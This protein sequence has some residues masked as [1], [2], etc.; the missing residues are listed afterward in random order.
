ME[1]IAFTIFA[2]LMQS[3]RTAGQKQM[4]QS[5]SAVVTT[6]ARYGFGFP[7]ALG[8]LVFM[9]N[10]YQQTLPVMSGIFIAYVCLAAVAQLIAT[11]LLVK[12]LSFRNFAVGT[13]YAKTEGLLAAIFAAIL[14]GRALSYVAWIAVVIG[15]VGI[16]FVSLQKSHLS[17]KNLFAGYPALLGI[18]AGIGFA[19][20]A[21]L[22]REAN[23]LLASPAPLSAAYILMLSVFI[24]G[25][26]CTVLV[27]WQ[28]RTNWRQL[29]KNLKVGWFVGI[30]GTLGSI[31]WYTAFAL[32]EAAVVKT[33]GQVEFIFTVIITYAFF[34]ERISQVEWIG[35]ALV[36]CSVL[37]L[38][39]PSLFAQ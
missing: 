16:V 4:T 35:M 20:T 6:W 34:K 29:S 39:S 22:V 18:G 5:L 9:L 25:V 33:L 37:L 38:L 32:Q 12:L 28:D 30:T 10:R 11:L 1:W 26:L 14:F 36:L 19:M 27:Q 7:V 31:G 13:T 15:V 21:V 3:V 23:Q 2:A 24:Q 8:Y 17:A